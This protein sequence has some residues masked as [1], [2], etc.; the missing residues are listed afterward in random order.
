MTDI[1]IS[2][3]LE[4]YYMDIARIQYGLIEPNIEFDD[5]IKISKIP[6]EAFLS[7]DTKYKFA[8]IPDTIQFITLDHYNYTIPEDTPISIKW[9]AECIVV[10]IRG[11]TPLIHHLPDTL[12]KLVIEDITPIEYSNLG[13]QLT[14][15]FKITLPG[16]LKYLEFQDAIIPDLDIV[17]Q[18]DDK[19]D[20]SNH[21]NNLWI[22]YN[23]VRP[24]IDNTNAM[25]IMINRILDR[26]RLNSESVELKFLMIKIDEA[27]NGDGS[28]N[29]IESI[30]DYSGID[31]SRLPDSIETLKLV[32][33][34]Y[35]P[36]CLTYTLPR[37]LKKLI[38]KDGFHYC[39]AKLRFL[40]WT[41]IWKT[42]EIELYSNGEW[43]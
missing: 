40:F 36:L 22:T 34:R 42:L 28:T 37:N 1:K 13:L 15:P 29:G 24:G 26:F 33:P 30:F 23:K 21:L 17:F 25:V 8:D 5:I 11:Y 31:I 16:N 4:L 32:I 9:P 27:F 19:S 7:N 10:Y 41:S 3:K 39:Y 2:K 20:H 12:L 6:R 35:Y 14:S 18:N 38:I 43:L